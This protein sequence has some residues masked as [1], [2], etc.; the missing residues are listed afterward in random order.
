MYTTALVRPGASFDLVVIS[1]D[2]TEFDN[3]LSSHEKHP[4]ASVW[5]CDCVTRMNLGFGCNDDG[6]L[7]L[8]LSFGSVAL[9][10]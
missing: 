6:L 2:C 1:P 5:C 9:V 3:E 10:P 4:E 7:T 8:T